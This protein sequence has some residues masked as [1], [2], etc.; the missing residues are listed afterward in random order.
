[1]SILRGCIF[2]KT[3]FTWRT[4]SFGVFVTSM[5]KQCPSLGFSMFIHICNIYIYHIREQTPQ[6]QTNCVPA[7]IPEVL[8]KETIWVIYT[9]TATTLGMRVGIGESSAN[10]LISM[11]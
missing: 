7:V 1:M 5:V 3:D 10:D 2:S 9:D 6:T 11:C 4:I 8:G